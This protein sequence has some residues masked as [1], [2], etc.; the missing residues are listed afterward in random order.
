MVGTNESLVEYPADMVEVRLLGGLRVRRRD[1]SLVDAR[2]WRT[3]KTADL[4]RLLALRGGEPVPVD[5]LLDTLW[6]SVDDTRGRASLRT[7][8]SQVRR[9]VGCDCI[10]RRFGGMALADAW[11][12]VVAFRGL[13]REARRHYEERQ[14]ERT[15]SVAREAAALYLGELSAHDSDADWVREERDLL[16][17]LHA[18]M[19]ADA[20]DA[21]L[22]LGWL[23]DALDL[24]ARSLR[25]DP[26]AERAYRVQIL[27]HAGLGETDRALRAFERCRVVLAEELGADPSALTH[28]AHLQVLQSGTPAGPAPA[29]FVGREQELS[30]L[31]GL[32][33]AGLAE[34]RP[35]A[36]LVSGVPG[37]GR[38][39]L[40][41][42]AC[43][44][45][46]AR[47]DLVAAG[48]AAPQPAVQVLAGLPVPAGP[49]VLVLT[50]LTAAGADDVAG[51]IERL[52]PAALVV[53]STTEEPLARPDL[54]TLLER[55]Q[56]TRVREFRLVGLRRDEVAALAGD[57]LGGRPTPELVAALVDDSA[58]VPSRALDRLGEWATS[59]RVVAGSRGLVLMAPDAGGRAGLDAPADLLSLQSQL[60][61]D[62]LQVLELVAL[63]HEAVD[64]AALAGVLDGLDRTLVEAGLRRLEDLAVLAHDAGRY[65]FRDPLLRD[66]TLAALRPSHRRRLHAAV[67]ERAPLPAAARLTHWL[68]AGEPQLACA[69]ALD[70][71]DAAVAGAR[72][73]EAREHLLQ[74]CSLGDLPQMVATDKIALFERLGDV[75]AILQLRTEASAAYAVALTVARTAGLG[76]ADR[77]AGKRHEIDAR[78]PGVAS[79][80]P[81]ERRPRRVLAERLAL[82]PA[83]VPGEELEITLR[84]AVEQADRSPE[85]TGDRVEARLLLADLLY[86]PQ[87]RLHEAWRWAQEGRALTVDP[88]LHAQA[89][90]AACQPGVLLGG[91]PRAV[92]ALEDAWERL[93]DGEEGEVRARIGLLLALAR[94]ELGRPGVGGALGEAGAL[95]DV[96]VL[97]GA[98]PAMSELWWAAVR[99]MAE[100]G[101]I[102]AAMRAERIGAMAPA[103]PAVAPM[104]ALATARLRLALHSPSAAARALEEGIDSARESGR[105]LLLPELAA[106]LAAL[107][108]PRDV[109][110]AWTLLDLAE[111]SL[112]E[113]ALG[114]E[115]V[116]INLGDAAVRA[117]TGHPVAAADRA[118]AAARAAQA[119]GLVFQR[120]EA[121]A[122]A[123]RYLRTAGQ[124]AEAVPVAQ[125]AADAY[126][127]AG[128]S[129]PARRLCRGAARQPGRSQGAG[130][131]VSGPYA[132]PD[133]D[134][135]SE[136][137]ARS[138][139][140]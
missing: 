7:A 132:D 89:T 35:S 83:P 125:A 74:V 81:A 14:F 118:V 66:A 2:E 88:L 135:G 104:R 3:G 6:P 1:G 19:L 18:T 67:A 131:E 109:E 15:V 107:R 57:L 13:A 8:A 43:R 82:V 76:D 42:E 17:S 123:A 53:T 91:A 121:L 29:T 24:A 16:G 136:G 39:R 23:R 72:Y 134:G 5:R 105:S 10:A 96:G 102:A 47:V 127:S 133:R 108:A 58:G 124:W 45:L 140:S 21:A 137:P 79:T 38:R 71:A 100:R 30:E 113:A 52:A 78:Q 63:L 49:S 84:A 62:H 114:R 4:L 51:E 90:A 46:A 37:I 60:S 64:A 93:P 87:R 41:A 103:E 110:A 48:P 73:L 44:G 27:A 75:C 22:Q 25:Q 85:D 65:S 119:S 129:G 120:A 112:G 68:D 99:M 97:A 36:V 28:S 20:A 95:G 98:G 117:V 138:A 122:T 40:V 56:P 50:D 33:Q 115:R 94:H 111:E 59:G 32:L 126:L 26:C 128:A 116:A 106:R 31:R 101:D 130:P 86:T 77:L 11:V 69:A 34:R 61:A 70:A 12:D 9:V 54:L 80:A 92:E 55:V 139:A